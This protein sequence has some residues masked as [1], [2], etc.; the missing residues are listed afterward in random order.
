[1]SLTALNDLTGLH[2]APKIAETI[3]GLIPETGVLVVDRDLTVVL[4]EGP[5]F[6]RHGFDPGTAIDR[7]VRDVLSAG[8]WESVGGYW[9]AALEGQAQ[10]LERDSLDGRAAYWLHFAP[11]ATT[12]GVVGAIM[13][14]QDIT[15]RVRHHESLER[16]LSQQLAV[17]S[18]GSLGLREMGLMTILEA[19]ANALRTELRADFAAVY[20]HTADGGAI[21]RAVV[22]DTAPPP[23]RSA[24]PDPGMD[25]SLLIRDSGE[26]MLSAD[27]RT[28][29]RFASPR[30]Q[31]MGM[32]SLV[33]APIGVGDSAFGFVG[34]CSGWEAAFSEDDLAFAQ[35]VANVA[36]AAAERERAAIEAAQADS[37]VTNLW[38]LSLDPLA[39][40][41]ADGTFLKASRGW[42]HVL[43]WTPEELVGKA[44][45]DFVHPDDRDATLLAADP[46]GSD[47]G[48]VP[49]VVNRLL[50]KDG[51]C[52]WLLWSVR[53]G[54][55]GHI[56]AVA[57]DITERYEERDLAAR[58][59]GQLNEAQ[60]LARMGSW[61]T[62]VG[63]D[64]FVVS[65]SLRSMLAL[66]SLTVPFR[67]VLARFHPDDR[68]MVEAMFAGR[69]LEPAEF[70][71]VLPDGTSRI[72]SSQVEP[73][74][75]GGRTT[76][77]RG[78]VL[79]VT[80]QRSRELAL[81]RSEE[82]FRQ[83]FENARIAVG[84]I[85]PA[86]GRYI[87]VNDALCRFLARSADELL[88]LTTTDVTHP[89]DMD[90]DVA[91][92][93]DLASG[94][95]VEYTCDQRY[96]RPD[97]SVVWGAL[98]ISTAREAD[99]T[100]DV[101][102]SQVLDITERKQ[103][104]AESR[105]K[106]GEVAWLAE[107][108][109][110]FEEDRFELHAQPVVEI[111]TGSILMHELLIRMRTGD[112]ELVAP[113]AFLP[114]AEKYG[115]IR[116]IDRWVIGRGADMAAS[117]M[118][119]AIN[120]S[121]VSLSDP[122]LVAHVKTEV[123][124]AHADPARITF[125]ITETALVEAAET[126]IRSVEDIRQLGCRIALDDF[127]TGFGGFHHL[128]TLTLDLL[129][130]DQDFVGSAVA[131]EPDR[132]LI[133]AVVNLAKRFGM[134]TVAEGVENQETLDLLARM[135]VDHAQGFHLGRPARLD[136]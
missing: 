71:V 32:V 60:R 82:R 52:R 4:M 19:A 134:Q 79:D 115:V 106:L 126:A 35:S 128:K 130:I 94:S 68:S 28:D 64:E 125:E 1:V 33:V 129:K 25:S 65:E 76:L 17:S 98:S 40:F 21:L 95:L 80:E 105:A 99:G 38:E 27:I 63:S 6:G 50:T 116:E 57:K 42:E 90:A 46:S 89:E 77:L 131:N 54:P 100:V 67:E 51:S 93:R 22:G 133:W 88:T 84:L 96:L 85:D 14:A 117:G 81:R 62:D 83:G 102:F 66:D 37:L 119:V 53:E 43:G 61:S 113:G 121:G 47:G 29:A 44:A 39:I 111:S 73:V 122:T 107:I 92:M 112:G 48:A 58:R 123:A 97:G 2:D 13:V 87:R 45:I 127:G 70:R 101:M 114:A 108:R 91:A 16:R 23:P 8:D 55:G 12:Q 124:R 41:A 10:T 109:L 20:E 7:D 5:V 69:S 75:E 136:Q 30:L 34:A 110:A 36:H 118:N 31:E 72:V 3:L 86:S 135:H 78:T 103:R 9:R 74:I 59:E 15:T 132:H 11:L 26:P 49:E 56:Y 120:V 104:E 24:A 18:L